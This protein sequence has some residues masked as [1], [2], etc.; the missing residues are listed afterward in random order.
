MRNTGNTSFIFWFY[1]V[2]P[3]FALS[4]AISLAFN[5]IWAVLGDIKN[6]S[7]VLYVVLITWLAFVAVKLDQGRDSI[8]GEN[9]DSLVY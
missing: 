7:A 8:K 1:F 2:L 3:G 5:Q 4:V 9:A 6:F